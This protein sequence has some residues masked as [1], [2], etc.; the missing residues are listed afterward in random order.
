MTDITVIISKY[1]F[2]VC[3][4]VFIIESGIILLAENGKL[5]RSVPNALTR[6]R[7]CIIFFHLMAFLIL[8]Y[9]EAIGRFVATGEML[10]TAVGM[11]AIIVFGNI[12]LSAIYK[13]SSLLMWN[14]L[15][16]I[17]DIGM[18]MLQR[19]NPQLAQKQLYWMLGGIII[20]MIIP[21]IFLI[22][23]RLNIFR[24][25]YLVL[26]FTLLLATLIFGTTEGGATNWI[27]IK[28]ISFQPAEAVKILLIFYL[29]CCFC[30]YR[31][32]RELTIPALASGILVLCLV[33]QKDLGTALIFFMAFMTM[34]Y[35]A[36][37]ST[38]LFAGGISMLA[39]ASVVAYNLFSHVRTRVLTWQNPWTDIQAGGY[40]ITQSLFAI[41]T[42]GPFGCGLSKG[43]SR[44]IPV[45]ERDFIF[46]A[47]CEELGIIFAICLILMYVVIFVCAFRISLES[48]NRFLCILCAGLTTIFT[49]QV[50]L[51]IGGVIKLIPLTGVTLP[52]ISYGGTSIIVSFL[53]LSIIQWIASKNYSIE[54]RELKKQEEAERGEVVPRRRRRKNEEID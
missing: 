18:V 31:N 13:G 37:G 17:A 32:L 12:L 19:L 47:I 42:W 35:I 2:T 6:Q 8:S 41:G 53:T 29:A 39:L 54:Q 1:L 20:A 52:F 45:V 22:L 25:F 3:S 11:L 50:F 36:T 34:L 5:E 21:L 10:Q 9:S 49:F 43:Y 38:L 30:E 51:I 4:L 46:S 24:N 14:C 33:F 26:G 23:P 40:Q 16:F 28:G 7:I 15:F 48:K 27:S 44:S